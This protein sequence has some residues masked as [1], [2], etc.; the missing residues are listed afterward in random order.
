MQTRGFLKNHFFYRTHDK[1]SKHVDQINSNI[2]FS[3]TYLWNYYI[4]IEQTL[5]SSSADQKTIKY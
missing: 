4:H 3:K 5:F 2:H 1:T